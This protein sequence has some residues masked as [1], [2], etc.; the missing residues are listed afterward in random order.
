MAVVGP[1]GCGKSDLIFRMLVGKTFYPKI[2]NVFYFYR[3]HQAIF[4]EM[5]KRL[6]IQFIQFTTL[7]ITK[8]LDNCL[9]VFDDSCEEIYNDKEF[10]KIATSGRHRQLHVIYV[11]H[12]LFQQSKFSRTIDLN[13]NY[14]IIFKSPRD[15]YQVEVLGKQLNDSNFV[16]ESY[17]KA[18]STP[19]GHLLIDLNPKTSDCLRYSSNIAEPGPSIF[20]LPTNLAVI[21]PLTNEKE[22]AMYTESF[23]SNEPHT[24]IKILTRN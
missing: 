12:N 23:A 3:E 8:Q 13:T 20:Y 10:S 17:E 22:R 5:Q 19:F 14:I 24:A 2:R 21:T 16:K 4:E 15:S 1:S 9:L 11:K 7:E 18:T 6:Q